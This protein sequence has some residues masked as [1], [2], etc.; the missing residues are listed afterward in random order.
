[1]KK[2]NPFLL[3]LFLHFYTSVSS[4]HISGAMQFAVPVEAKDSN[5]ISLAYSNLF[6]FRDYEYFN[7]IQTGYTLFGTWHYPRLVVQPNKW[8]R[9][10]AGALLQKDFGDK[11]L[12]RAWP[13]FSVQLQQKNFRIILGALEG[14]QSHQLTEPLMS[15]DK[16]IER[17]IEEGMQLKFNSK[18]ITTDLWLDW[19]L[20]QKE[21]S[22]SPEELT[23]GLALN[24]SLTRPGKPLQ[25]KIPIAFIMPHKGGQLDTNSSVVT[26]AFN[27][28]TG[29]SAEWKNPDE[30][31]WLKEIKT[32]AHYTGYTLF[33]DLNVYPYSKGSGFLLNFLLKSKWDISFLSTYWKGSKYIAPRGGKLYQSI[34]SIPGR[35]YNEPERQLLFLN[36]IYDKEVYPGFFID[37]RYSPYFD[38][39]NHTMEH[40]FLIL[41]SY[42]NIFR[43]GTLK[44]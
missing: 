20:R 1:M 35:N 23:G 39:R 18:R 43:L 15:F 44:K 16:V 37:A 13:V 2:L 25:V 21:N 4:Q 29:I 41:F 9:L 26:T 28:S 34:S 36:M 40:A 22:S 8:L 3:I 11:Q 17:P 10:E 32:D 31:K 14:N 33:Q 30:Q 7:S 19:E 6:Y 38:L 24:F 27:K 5:S 12:S 42:R